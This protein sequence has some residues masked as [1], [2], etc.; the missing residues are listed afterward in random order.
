MNATTKK[1]ASKIQST[2]KSKKGEPQE[3]EPIS[4]DSAKKRSKAQETREP[5]SDHHVSASATEPAPKAKRGRKPKPKPVEYEVFHS[6]G[7]FFWV[8]LEKARAKDDRALVKALIEGEYQS[9][10]I[11]NIPAYFPIELDSQLERIFDETQNLDKAWNPP[12]RSTSVGDIV[13]VGEEFW[14]VAS[15]GYRKLPIPDE[16]IEDL[17]A[18]AS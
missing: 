15:V 7:E 8:A 14:V 18:R 5:D 11:S 17:K 13:R 12:N 6:M 3:N 4:I 10:F 1:R 9:V 2:K 16:I